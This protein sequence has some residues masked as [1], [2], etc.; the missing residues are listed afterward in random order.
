MGDIADYCIEQIED[1]IAQG[2]ICG[3]CYRLLEFQ[4]HKPNCP[5]RDKDMAEDETETDPCRDDEVMSDV[6]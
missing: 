5:D 4:L 6:K 2:F 1:A 3:N